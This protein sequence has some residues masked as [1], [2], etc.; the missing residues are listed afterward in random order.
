MGLRGFAALI[1]LGLV[2]VATVWLVPLFE[3]QW[4]RTAPG[5]MRYGSDQQIPPEA[6]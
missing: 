2:L 4:I 1:P 6:L 5:S 3:R